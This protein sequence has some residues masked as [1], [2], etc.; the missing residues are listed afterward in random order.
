MTKEDCVLV[1]V[2]SKCILMKVYG[3]WSCRA[4][5]KSGV[6]NDENS[7]SQNTEIGMNTAWKDHNENVSRDSE[8]RML[9]EN[10]GHK[11]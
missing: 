9:S 8:R 5:T 3:M 4:E 2:R 7:K 6:Y 10:V 11:M 1:T